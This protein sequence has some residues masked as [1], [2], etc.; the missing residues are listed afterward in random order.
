MSQSSSD[1]LRHVALLDQLIHEYLQQVDEGQT[2]NRAAM[3]QQHPELANE[4]AAFFEDQDRIA[5]FAQQLRLQDTVGLAVAEERGSAVGTDNAGGLPRSVRYFGRY[6]ILQEIARGG[7]GVVYKA[8][9]SRLDRIVAL[10]M[11]L[12][13]RLASNADVARFYSEA[14]AAANLDHPGIV[15]IYEVGQYGGQHYFS[16]AYVEGESLAAALAKGPLPPHDAAALVQRLCEAVQYAHQRGVIHRD[17]KPANVLIDSARRPHITDF[18]LAKHAGADSGLTATGQVLGTPSYMPPEQAAGEV[19]AIG[20][21]ADIYSLGAVLYAALTGRPPF[22]AATPLDT[23]MQVCSS[24]PVSPRLLNPAVSRD[25][26]TICLK[27]LEK[28]P[29]RRYASA[30]DVAEDLRRFLADEP[31]LARRQGP[32]VQTARW[33]RKRRKTVTLV[34]GS[35]AAAAA[36]L[37]GGFFTWRS[38]EQAKLGYLSLTT[39]GPG[40]VAELFDNKWRP[41]APSFPVPSS[42]PLELPEGSYR[43]RISS[44]GIVSETYSLNISRGDHV[45]YDAH[46][47][48]RSLWPPLEMTPGDFVDPVELPGRGTALLRYRGPD[49]SFRLLDGAT[50]K[51]VWPQDL[52][53]DKNNLPAGE[54]VEEWATLLSSGTPWQT[55]PYALF[56]GSPEAE[57]VV[58]LGSRRR[59]ALIAVSAAT[60]KVLWMFRGLPTVEGVKDPSH[61]HPVVNS[62]L[63][64]VIGKPVVA[65]SGDG[66]P[67]VLAAFFSSGEVFQ[68]D[69]EYVNADQQIWLEAVSAKT[70]KSLWRR[71]I[72]QIGKSMGQQEALPVALEAIEQPRVVKLGDHQ[73]VLVANDKRLYGFDLSTG[74]DAWPPLELGFLIDAAPEIVVD[75]KGAAAPIATFAAGRLRSGSFTQSVTLTITAISLDDRR[76]L[77]Q[78]KTDGFSP[79]SMP[80]VS[81]NDMPPFE[82]V[83]LE[84]GGMP[85]IV[86]PVQLQTNTGGQPLGM[87]KVLDTATGN[88][89]WSQPL[90]GTNTFVATPAIRL[91]IGPDLD[92]DGYREIFAA[93]VGH[94]PQNGFS[95]IVA[96]F[97]GRDG[98]TLWRWMQPGVTPG[99]DVQA[100]LCWWT[101]A[102]SGQPRLVV[103]VHSG[104]NGNGQGATVILDSA[105]GSLLETLPEVSDPRSA[106][107]DGDGL[108]DLFYTVKPQGYARLMTVRGTPPAPWRRLDLELQVAGDLNHDGIA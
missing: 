24:D 7:M 52:V 4:L 19:S 51:P 47:E 72:K 28:E 65:K 82:L 98:R 43:A 54:N 73:V 44:P 26:A 85:A 59:P 5:Q 107:L 78:I 9:Q 27:C 46:L 23:L 39:N 104:L 40:L 97:S 76:Q 42:Q 69:G 2:P 14:Q 86:A 96:A 38:H 30:A 25:L 77:W 99:A 88:A 101:P 102:A 89:R 61:L 11:I 84:P 106:D 108:P 93:W 3:V 100:G 67:I 55:P 22:Q 48:D 58:I 75:P 41:V 62:N 60:G 50:G 35:I 57:S 74:K 36:V 34:L 66:D 13:G 56:K 33:V 1:N 95:L 29:E 79:R 45:G 49:A 10:K 16:M 32:L 17:L 8:R 70:G 64:P 12:T 91:L 103:P 80:H 15:P 94:S 81:P 31:I 105:D 53:L 18:G 63:A 20:P 68:A 6:E 92:G 90:L 37:I 21:A 87:L 83:A 71:S